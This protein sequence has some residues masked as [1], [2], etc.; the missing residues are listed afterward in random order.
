VLAL[1][2]SQKSDCKIR[3]D[4]GKFGENPALTRNRN[5]FQNWNAK[6]ECLTTTMTPNN[7]VEDCGWSWV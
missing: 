4:Q 7:T 6:S 3:S 5:A 2:G 1:Q